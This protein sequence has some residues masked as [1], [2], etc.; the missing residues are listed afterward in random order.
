M[1][2]VASVNKYLANLALWNIKLHNLHFNVE[3]LQF[4]GVHEY[5]EETY[6]EVFEYYD[7]VAELMK[8][9]G[10]MPVTN[11]KGYLEIATMEEKDDVAVGIKDALNILVGDLELMR[12]MAL[13]IREEA[14]EEGNFLLANM[15]EDHV[16][17]YAK[18]LWFVNSALK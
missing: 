8:Q 12:D 16:E 1:K 13:A 14:D 17:E 9:Q 5:L 2:N 6:D 4:K 18:R 11:M 7:E 15:M 3:G 10:E